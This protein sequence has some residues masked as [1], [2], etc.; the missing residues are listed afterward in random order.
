MFPI[1]DDDS[2]VTAVPIVTYVLI[3]ANIL[4]FLFE[5]SAGDQFVENWAF[6]PSHFR[7]SPATEWPTIFTAMFMHGGW[8]HLFGNMLYLYIFGDNVEDNFGHVK[9]LVFYLVAG[10]AATFAQ[11]VFNEGSS[12]PN[13]GASG[14]I[15]GVLGAYILMFPQSR[16]DVLVVRQVISMPAVVVIGFWIVLQL[17]SGVGSIANTG[18][19]VGGVAYM[20]HV[21]GFAAGFVIALL[22]GRRSGPSASA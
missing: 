1:G 17:F 5:L 22:F 12:I 19:D 14:A 15:A 2:E 13:V 21:G 6:I 10:I 18:A 20:A 9:Y 8:M 4:F 11:Y 7:E 3:A 16:V